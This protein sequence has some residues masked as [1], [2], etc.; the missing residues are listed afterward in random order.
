MESVQPRPA[1]TS[2]AEEALSEPWTT[3]DHLK[4]LILE[5]ERELSEMN[6][7]RVQGLEDIIRNKDLAVSAEIR[8]HFVGPDLCVSEHGAAKP[9]RFEQLPPSSLCCALLASSYEEKTTRSELA[10]ALRKAEGGFPVQSEAH[11]GSGCGAGAVRRAVHGAQEQHSRAGW[12]DLRAARQDRGAA[13]QERS[14]PGESG[15]AGGI[16]RHEDGRSSR[17]GRRRASQIRARASEGEGASR[18][19]AKEVGAGPTS[20]GGGGAYW[21]ATCR[22]MP[23]LGDLLVTWS[24]ICQPGGRAAPGPSVYL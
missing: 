16:P 8:H 7:L 20:E 1:E 24:G 5:K 9:S 12:R 19:T 18:G 2:P 13:A 22:G 10:K 4:E 6:E 15:R 21:K 11:R 23:F 14:P 17:E 3:D